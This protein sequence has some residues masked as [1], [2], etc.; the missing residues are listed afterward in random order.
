MWY[1]RLKNNDQGYKENAWE[2][3]ANLKGMKSK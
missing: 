3:I 2:E 1:V